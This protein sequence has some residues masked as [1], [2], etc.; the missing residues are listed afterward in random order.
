MDMTWLC[1]KAKPLILLIFKRVN[2]V[3]FQRYL[4]S[5]IICISSYAEF[6]KNIGEKLR[7]RLGS[8]DQKS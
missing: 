5:E 2:T 6:H 1:L 4:F 8:N 3:C 7:N